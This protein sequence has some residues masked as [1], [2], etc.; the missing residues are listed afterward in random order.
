MFRMMESTSFFS[1]MEMMRMRNKKSTS[2]VVSYLIWH[3]LDAFGVSLVKINSR[4]VL[5]ES[6]I[7]VWF[8]S[9]NL[10]FHSIFP[11]IFR[12]SKVPELSKIE[13]TEATNK[14]D[15]KFHSYYTLAKPI[16]NEPH[17]SKKIIK[18]LIT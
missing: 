3:F 18:T 11:S 10:I 13:V 4:N 7:D 15:L 5:I 12:R 2:Y 17:I 6:K 1:N 16:S 9:C 14:L 8:T